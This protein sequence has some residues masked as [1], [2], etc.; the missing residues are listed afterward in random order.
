MQD[1]GLGGGVGG[2]PARLGP[3]G[4]ARRELGQR[5]HG[6]HLE[7]EARQRG[8]RAVH[9]PASLPEKR[10]ASVHQLRYMPSGRP[11]GRTPSDMEPLQPAPNTLAE[12]LRR[13]T[14][15][16]WVTP[17]LTVALTAGFFVSS[18]L[19][20]TTPGA[21][22]AEQL[23]QA[24]ANYFPLTVAQGQ[25]WRLATSPWV[26]AGIFH[27][28]LNV[29]AFWNA[30]QLTERLF[31]NVA[32]GVLVLSAALASNVAG[33]LVNPDTVLTGFSGAVFGVYGALLAFLVRRRAQLPDGVVRALRGTTV[34]FLL[35]NVVVSATIPFVTNAMSV[36]GLAVG[37]L[38][39]WALARDLFH[40]EDGRPQRL[41]AL[42]ALVVVV[43]AATA[44]LPLRPG[45]DA[46]RE[47]PQSWTQQA[48]ARARLADHVGAVLA[49]GK[50]LAAQPDDVDARLGRADAHLALGH[51]L[52]ALVDL[53]AAER[54]KPGVAGNARW[55]EA[56]VR[57]TDATRALERCD[58]V[59]LAE[60]LF[61]QAHA[62]L[63]RALVLTRLGRHTEAH[64][65]VDRALEQTGPRYARVGATRAH[66]L[67]AQGD[68]NAVVA[69]CEKTPIVR[70]LASLELCAWALRDVRA[71][72]AGEQLFE[73]AKAMAGANVADLDLR[74]ALFF[75]GLG[76]VPRALEVADGLTGPN[77]QNDRAW[78]HVLAQDAPR[79]LALA[80][81]AVRDAPDSPFA[82]GTRC[83]ARALAGDL[84]GAREDCTRAVAGMP[85]SDPDEGMLAFLRGD[86]ATAVT[87]WKVAQAAEP[88]SASL[89]SP[90]IAKA[91]AGLTLAPASASADGGPADAGMAD[92][93]TAD[94]G[95]ADG[96]P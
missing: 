6:Q 29:W 11:V 25:W 94:A 79:A 1:A 89:F 42:A 70:D 36:G 90:W 71:V 38:G 2:G 23:V 84:G 83:W 93:G 7:D 22:S 51:G 69:L 32:F 96:G 91:K 33:L 66:V 59:K 18:W 85:G 10:P 41:T 26:H 50:V 15:R 45:A 52:A 9:G 63:N 14:P 60:G 55:C 39:G 68:Q 49:Y 37:L 78:V 8:G 13:V 88:W 12:L 67:A 46:T 5:D 87:R 64:Q 56:L 57:S 24:G 80:D 21:P 92:G 40:P 44:A 95:M 27:L 20:G 62:Q 76:D 31:G 75:L 43:I 47:T 82:L 74:R 28:L 61:T 16:L 48:R 81:A 53:E 30:G 34:T 17:A 4:Q 58:A 65:A 35:L 19:W 54:A 77:A 72:G 3:G 86:A 73:R